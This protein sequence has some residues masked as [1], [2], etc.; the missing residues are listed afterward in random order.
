MRPLDAATYARSARK[1]DDQMALMGDLP[2][3]NF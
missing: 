3:S 2:G 1:Y